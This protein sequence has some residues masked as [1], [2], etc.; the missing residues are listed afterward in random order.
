MQCFRKTNALHD[1]KAILNESFAVI[2]SLYQSG[3]HT[4]SWLRLRLNNRIS[5]PA[6]FDN[7]AKWNLKGGQRTLRGNANIYVQFVS[8]APS[9]L[10]LRPNGV[11]WWDEGVKQ[12]KKCK[13]Q[14]YS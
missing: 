13:Y 9:R 4:D 10:Y 11:W 2:G 3:F 6:C 7:S 5:Y 8:E 1:F 12:K 14:V